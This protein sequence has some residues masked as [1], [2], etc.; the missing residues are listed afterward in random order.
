MRP[1][2][3]CDNCRHIEIYQPSVDVFSG[4]WWSIPQPTNPLVTAEHREDSQ[5]TDETT[6]IDPLVR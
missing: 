1:G 5:P 6:D 2:H 4:D 3:A